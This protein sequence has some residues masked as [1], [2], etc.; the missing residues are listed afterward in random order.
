MRHQGGSDLKWCMN[1]VGAAITGAYIGSTWGAPWPLFAA[2]P[3]QPTPHNTWTAH[4]GPACIAA[5][6]HQGLMAGVGVRGWP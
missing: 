3:P 6:F 1:R 2:I 4:T 5:Q